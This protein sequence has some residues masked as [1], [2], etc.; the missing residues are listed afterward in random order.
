MS[1]SNREVQLRK[2]C[3]LYTY[4]LTSQGKEIPEYLQECLD[5]DGYP[6]D[7]VKELYKE[8]KDLDS[9]TFEQ[10]VHDSQSPQAQDLARWWEMYQIYIPIEN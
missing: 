3:Q 6:I 10:I 1:S 8:L 2:T 9:E 4:V 5:P 7:C